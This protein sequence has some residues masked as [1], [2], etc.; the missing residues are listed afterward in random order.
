MLLQLLVLIELSLKG[1]MVEGVFWLLLLLRLVRRIWFDELSYLLLEVCLLFCASAWLA[2]LTH[3]T[4]CVTWLSHLFCSWGWD[5]ILRDLVFVFL[6][7]WESQHL[8]FEVIFFVLIIIVNLWVWTIFLDIFRLTHSWLQLCH[9]LCVLSFQQLILF[10][11]LQHRFLSYCLHL[12]LFLEF[13]LEYRDFL[14][15]WGFFLLHWRAFAVTTIKN[16]SFCSVSKLK[17]WK[18]FS[19]SGHR[20]A[21]TDNESHFSLAK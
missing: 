4:Y 1:F 10:F 11:H 14:F 17:S 12:S 19:W 15:N 18:S 20:R 3:L 8:I 9:Q 13:S 2:Y 7:N 16:G 6:E 5:S 21:D